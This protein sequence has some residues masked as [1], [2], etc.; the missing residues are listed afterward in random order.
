MHPYTS[1]WSVFLRE[2][3]CLWSWYHPPSVQF[4]LEER[5]LLLAHSRV[6]FLNGSP[7]E[8]QSSENTSAKPAVCA[9]AP[10]SQFA[11]LVFLIHEPLSLY[12]S[13]GIKH[14]GNPGGDIKTKS[15]HVCRT[16]G[17]STLISTEQCSELT[18]QASDVHQGTRECPL[19]CDS[20][21]NAILLILVAK[22]I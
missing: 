10:S 17:L 18:G 19:D 5:N 9:V 22:L 1:N 20:L 16:R 12:N 21:C 7:P 11:I 4:P 6:C 13:R 15:C 3:S 14:N 8:A 2:V